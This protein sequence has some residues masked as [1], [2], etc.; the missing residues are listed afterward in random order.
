MITFIHTNSYASE[1]RLIKEHKVAQEVGP[2]SLL[3][4]DRVGLGEKEP[5]ACYLRLRAPYGKISFV[6]YLP[7]WFIF[8]S[9]HLWRIRPTVIHACNFEGFFP[10]YCYSLF[11]RTPVIFDLWDAL[12]GRFPV[13]SKGLADILKRIDRFCLN[14]SSAA[15]VPDPER[16]KQIGVPAKTISPKWQVIYNSDT[17]THTDQK[18]SFK[19]KI[20]ITVSYVGVMSSSIRGLEQIIGLASSNRLKRYRFVIA[21]YG[22]DL[23][24]LSQS[25][26]GHGS[27]ID[28]RGRVTHTAAKKIVNDTDIIISLLD[29]SFGNYQY[30][31]STKIFEAFRFGKPV[32]TTAG[33]ASGGLVEQTGW[34]I[35]IPYNQRA[36]ES[37]LD[38]IADGKIVFDLKT[39]AVTP[40]SWPIMSSR[41]KTIYLSYL[42]DKGI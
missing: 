19:G 31:T 42:E 37:A 28:F 2:T 10:A 8:V 33:T 27:N 35:T 24:A 36:L 17:V 15:L 39:R 13:T 38:N 1:P 22:P 25:I 14:H 40:F 34:G 11:T 21:G 20:P 18:L 12:V 30:A 41:L 26:E 4:W 16:F 6:L 29:P 3:L 23:E 9:F 7:I 5:E 32:I